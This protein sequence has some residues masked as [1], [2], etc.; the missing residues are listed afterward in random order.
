LF[1]LRKGYPFTD[2]IAM[3]EPLDGGVWLGT[4]SEVVW[5]EGADIEKAALRSKLSYGAIPGASAQCSRDMVL[6]GQGDGTVVT[7]AT[8][9]GV[10]L[11][12]G[13]GAVTNLT[14]DRYWYPI[15]ETGAA[16]V[17]KHRGMTQAVVTLRGAETAVNA[18]P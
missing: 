3:V 18:T 16:L 14:H 11:G 10:C 17:R 7:F 12:D 15:Q 1:D 6:D 8:V 5:L 9:Q 2:D 4:R 13:N